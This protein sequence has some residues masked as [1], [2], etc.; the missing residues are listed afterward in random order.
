VAA[1]S[2]R[3]LAPR[4]SVVD[5][6]DDVVWSRFGH[7]SLVYRIDAFHEPGLDGADFNSAALLAENCWTGLPEGTFYQFY[8]FVDQRRG[9][10][11]L[12]QALPPIAGENPKER[13][14]EEFRKA[15]LRELTREEE[16]GTAANLV[17]DRRHYL[18]ATFTPVLPR[19]SALRR[20]CDDAMGRF[21]TWVGGAGSR[22]PDGH[23]TT[24]YDTLVE[25]SRR[26]RS[27][28]GGRAL[29]DGA[30]IRAVLDA[31]DRPFGLRAP[32]PD[33]QRHG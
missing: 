32:E 31:G 16:G 11:R 21:T 10:R 3:S 2:E 5:I 27:T 18:C 8:V 7:L 29:A 13:L 12:V 9:V 25:Q 19:P 28:G 1:V 4:I 22:H 20:A 6:H 33:G 30:G 15:R 14:F 24:T 17:Q 23:W 26:F